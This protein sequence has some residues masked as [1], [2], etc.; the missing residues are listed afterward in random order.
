[1]RR[2]KHRIHIIHRPDATSLRASR[3]FGRFARQL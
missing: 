2:L 3:G 1:M